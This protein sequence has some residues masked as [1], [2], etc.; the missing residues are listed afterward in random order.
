MKRLLYDDPSLH[1]RGLTEIQI[2]SINL[3]KITDTLITIHTK[4]AHVHY[5]SNNSHRQCKDLLD[6]QKN[7]NF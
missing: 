7:I 6:I 4:C 3:C 1:K 2:T 5:T